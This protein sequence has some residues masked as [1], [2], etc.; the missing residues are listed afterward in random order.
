MG[1]PARFRAN[2]PPGAD[3]SGCSGRPTTR[4]SGQRWAVVTTGGRAQS[5]R[6]RPARVIVLGAVFGMLFEPFLVAHAAPKI[7]PRTVGPAEPLVKEIVERPMQCVGEDAAHPTTVAAGPVALTERVCRSPT[8]DRIREQ[9]AKDRS[10]R[11]QP[12][13]RSEAPFRARSNSQ[14]SRT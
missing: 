13:T 11:D 2:P 3:R 8:P 5:A 7:P 1:S 14:R 9:S 6:Q 4:L 10:W 12:R